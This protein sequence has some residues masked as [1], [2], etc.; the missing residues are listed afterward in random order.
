MT[1]QQDNGQ[2]ENLPAVYDPASV[3]PDHLWRA[4][5][6]IIRDYGRSHGYQA[7]RDLIFHHW[8]QLRGNMPGYSA[9]KLAIEFD[10]HAMFAEVASERAKGRYDTSLWSQYQMYLSGEVAESPAAGY[11]PKESISPSDGG[12]HTVSEEES[13]P[14]NVE[15]NNGQ[16]G[17]T[18]LFGK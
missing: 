12:A 6:G 14:I 1:E 13:E 8:N 11:V 16:D 18:E 15:E 3:D 7:A 10:R 17:Q 4:I 5:P 9:L 2:S